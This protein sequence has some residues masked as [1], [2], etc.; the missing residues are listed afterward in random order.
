MGAYQGLTVWH[1]PIRRDSEVLREERV[2][3]R[4]LSGGREDGTARALLI[5]ALTS[6]RTAL[7]IS[8][9]QVATRMQ[10]QQSAVSDLEKGDSDP[11]LSTLQR[12]ARAIG[13]R[14]DLGLIEDLDDADP[15]IA[16]SI[17]HSRS[18]RGTK[19][20]WQVSTVQ[21]DLTA[22]ASEPW[23]TVLD[24]VPA[25]EEIRWQSPYEVPSRFVVSL[26]P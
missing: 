3:Q 14:L 20:P 6:L 25:I 2:R 17:E 1:S 12:Y 4:M 10:T 21:K 18:W 26:L 9:R 22:D 23:R 7:G 19:V 5:Q 24:A 8:Q 11:R 15:I 16:Q 13:C